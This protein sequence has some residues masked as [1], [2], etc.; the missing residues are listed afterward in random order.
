MRERPEVAGVGACEETLALV[1][2]IVETAYIDRTVGIRHHHAMAG[3]S[4]HEAC[5]QGDLDSAITRP[6][7]SAT[8]PT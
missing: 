8:R 3:P 2:G 4:L 5:D 6:R 1:A 7:W